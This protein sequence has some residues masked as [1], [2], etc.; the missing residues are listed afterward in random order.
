MYRQLYIFAAQ[1][2]LSR[3]TSVQDVGTCNSAK[4]KLGLLYRNFYQADQSVLSHLYKALVLPK[5]DYCSSVWDPHAVTQIDRLESVQRF[6]AKLCTKRWSDPPSQLMMSLRWP[7]L[8]TRRSRQ[9]AFLCRRIIKDESVIPSHKFFHPHPNPN[10]RTQHTCPVLVPF[11]RTISFQSSF[12]VSACR[13]WNSLPTHVI[14]R[15][16]SSF[17]FKSSLLQLPSFI[18]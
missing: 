10:P 3:V 14:S 4:R 9:K 6:A 1:F 12:F 13:L 2:A 18:Y 5:L 17:L 11:A 8:R 16:S 7:S 15:V